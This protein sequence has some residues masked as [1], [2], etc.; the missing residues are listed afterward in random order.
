MATGDFWGRRELK[1]R[2][3]EVRV[4]LEALKTQRW[5]AEYDSKSESERY[6]FRGLVLINGGAAVAFGALLQAIIGKPEAQAYIPWVIAA[7]AACAVGVLPASLAF[8]LGYRQ[9]IEEKRTGRFLEHNPWWKAK[10]AAAFLSGGLFLS[11]VAVAV[12]GGY[13]ALRS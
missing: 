5:Q 1:L 10:W 11:G 13:V 7:V 3:A 9:W 12:V 8:W 4:Q 2:E 6:G